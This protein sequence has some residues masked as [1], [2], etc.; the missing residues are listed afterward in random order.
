MAG[1]IPKKDKRQVIRLAAI[2]I[3]NSGKKV[4]SLQ[5]C[6]MK[7]IKKGDIFIMLEDTL[8]LVLGKDQKFLYRAKSDGM[9]HKDTF[10]V[11]AEE[12]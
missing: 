7:D 1:S 6:E 12:I 4:L 3:N 10:V 8:E 2:P 5:E 11:Q 9:P